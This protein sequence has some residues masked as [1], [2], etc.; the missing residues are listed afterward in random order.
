MSQGWVSDPPEFSVQVVAAL[1]VAERPEQRC[2]CSKNVR[3]HRGG[4]PLRVAGNESGDDLPVVPLAPRQLL[5][6][7]HPNR[8]VHE[9]DLQKLEQAFR[10][11]GAPGPLNEQAMELAVEVDE[12]AHTLGAQFLPVAFTGK[13]FHVL[14]EPLELVEGGIVHVQAG[15]RRHLG[16]KGGAK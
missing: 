1:A 8:A 16:L 3:P 15:T 6:G 7:I 4:G 5:R 9:R 13:P 10:V 11:P 14:G 2:P 12:T